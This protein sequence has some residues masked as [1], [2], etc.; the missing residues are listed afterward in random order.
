MLGINIV[1]EVG[2]FKFSFG[3]F[4]KV[5]KCTVNKIKIYCPGETRDK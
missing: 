1:E 3:N 2:G 5:G 4:Q